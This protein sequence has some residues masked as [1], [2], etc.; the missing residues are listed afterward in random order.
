MKKIRSEKLHDHLL[1]VNE[2]I[3]E[4]AYNIDDAEKLKSYTQQKNAKLKRKHAFAKYA[5]IAA[6]LALIVAALI[7]VPAFLDADDGY[8][9]G[10]GDEEE[11]SW[12]FGDLGDEYVSID[13]LDSLNYYSAV[14]ILNEENAELSLTYPQKAKKCTNKWQNIAKATK[15]SDEENI[16]YYEIDPEEI[17]SVTQV[18]MFQIKVTDKNCFLA[19]KVGLGIVD[20]VITDNSLEPMITFKNGGR[21]YSCLQN[22]G[23]PNDQNFSTHKYVEGFCIV[24]NLE[25]EI[26]SFY[27]E[28]DRKHHVTSFESA[29]YGS[30]QYTDG[31]HEVLR[32][33]FVCEGGWDFKISDLEKYYNANK[34]QEIPDNGLASVCVS[35]EYKFELYKDNTFIFTHVD[36]DYTVY[37]MGEYVFDEEKVT[38]IFLST[39]GKTVVERVECKLLEG[40]ENGF[41]YMGEK[42]IATEPTGGK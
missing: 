8:F 35:G 25:E 3:L 36:G 9:F 42:F 22:G 5:L 7:L 34:P 29:T 32:E 37:R 16:Y 31:E 15:D 41:I 28:F 38:L 27:V 30:V 14:R 17:F 33:T 19:D 10:D 13:S 23:G 12:P 6:C 18:V 11:G 40:D 20:V 24:K 4:N 26:C 2:D 1:N 39:D 21:F